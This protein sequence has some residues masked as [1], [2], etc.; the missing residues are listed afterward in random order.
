[1]IEPINIIPNSN[2]KNDYYSQLNKQSNSK[3][4]IV[5]ENGFGQSMPRTDI[6]EEPNKS[7]SKANSE[8][9]LSGGLQNMNE[10]LNDITSITQVYFQFELSEENPSDIIL[11][12]IDKHTDEVVN[13][14][15]SDISLKI[16]KMIEQFVG[17]G[18]L[19]DVSI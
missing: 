10:L 8:K 5:S 3:T 9:T 2:N 6:K 4:T 17:R 11:K 19:S 14:Y 15:P 1:M 12:V 7:D 13:Q 16:M 18:Q